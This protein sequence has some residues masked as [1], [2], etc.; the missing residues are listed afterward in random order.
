MTNRFLLLLG[1][2]VY[3]SRTDVSCAKQMI[4]AYQQANTS[5]IGITPMSVDIIHKAGC[6]GGKWRDSINPRN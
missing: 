4:D 2:H 1:D 5:V 6:V 3:T